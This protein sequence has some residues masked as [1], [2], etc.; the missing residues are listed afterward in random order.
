MDNLIEGMLILNKHYC[1][2]VF[3]N[4]E[5]KFFTCKDEMNDSDVDRLN[6]LGFDYDEE[7]D[8]FSYYD[9]DDAIYG[10][11]LWD[12]YDYN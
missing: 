3:F 7:N 6:E 10:N 5:I 11:E 12:H 2:P 4:G 1:E 9:E 8:S